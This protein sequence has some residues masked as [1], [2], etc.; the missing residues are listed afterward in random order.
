MVTIS[1]PVAEPPDQ[2]KGATAGHATYVAV[3]GSGSDPGRYSLPGIPFGTYNFEVAYGNHHSKSRNVAVSGDQQ[4]IDFVLDAGCDSC[5]SKDA[6]GF[7][8]KGTLAGMTVIVVVLFV[9]SIWLVRW[10][11]IARP[12]R[13]LLSAEID[14]TQARF[15]NE[16]GRELKQGDPVT[17]HLW[18]LLNAAKVA[19][20]QEKSLGDY[21]FW[22]RGQEITGWSRIYE[23]QRD[24]IKLFPPQ[25]LPLI[26]ARLQAIELDLLDIDKTHAKTMAGNIKDLIEK[27][28]VEEADLRAMLIEALTY[29]NDENDSR[30]AQLVGWQTKSVWLVGVGSA[31]IIVLAFAVGNPV[32]FIAGAA[33][34]YLSRMARQLKRADVPTDYGASW[35]TLFLSPILGALSGWFGIL[36]V[37]LLADN[38]LGV[39]GAAFQAIEWCCPLAPLTLGLAFA[40]GFSERLFD[41]IISS[42]EAKVD[43]DRHAATQP[44]QPSASSKAPTPGPPVPSPGP[45][46]APAPGPAAAPANPGVKQ[47]PPGNG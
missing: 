45:T 20:A 25:S 28:G 41:G 38:K 23:F 44:K 35:T 3:T 11:N 16:T 46:P 18:E 6:K 39:L 36:L 12:N 31:L 9:L 10:H 14:K 27:Q 26:R 2:T 8:T 34:G 7:W 21:L 24:S 42:L 15:T 43:S 5:D 32:L 29:L 33:G 19:L 37:I 40:L 13:E 30:F 22:S 17:G 47:Q 4:E 1:G